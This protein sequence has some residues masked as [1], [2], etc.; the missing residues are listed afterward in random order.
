MHVLETVFNI[1]WVAL[2]ALISVGFVSLFLHGFAS[3]GPYCP[4]KDPSWLGSCQS[5]PNP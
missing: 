5:A 1:I 3:T 2:V 4:G